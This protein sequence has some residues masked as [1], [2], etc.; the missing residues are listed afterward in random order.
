[1]NK[2]RPPGSENK[3]P[4]TE[5]KNRNYQIVTSRHAGNENIYA[6][7]EDQRFC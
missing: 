3:Q 5:I 2:A 7:I 4:L 1:M 6:S